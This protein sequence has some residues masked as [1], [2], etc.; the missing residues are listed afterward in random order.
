MDRVTARCGCI[1]R[2]CGEDQH[3][4]YFRDGSYQEVWDRGTPA[5]PRVVFGTRYTAYSD[6]AGQGFGGLNY[7]NVR[8][9][10]GG[11][12]MN[13]MNREAAQPRGQ[14]AW[15]ERYHDENNFEQNFDTRGRRR[16]ASVPRDDSHTNRHYYVPPEERYSRFP[17]HRNVRGGERGPIYRFARPESSHHGAWRGHHE[18]HFAQNVSYPRDVPLR[19]PAAAPEARQG[20]RRGRLSLARWIT[21]CIEI[22]GLLGLYFVQIADVM[23]LIAL[24]ALLSGRLVTETAVCALLARL[25]LLVAASCR[26][27][28]VSWSYM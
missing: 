4:I 28:R 13:G 14:H 10:N 22:L 9:N 24:L 27:V 18:G 8:S 20:P 26:R 11:G 2:P 1:F 19:A 6:V 12:R 25:A 15:F 17:Y 7:N 16:P 5:R 23:L 21:N 3:V